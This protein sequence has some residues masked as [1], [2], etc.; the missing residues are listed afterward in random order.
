MYWS[1]VDTDI[2]DGALLDHMIMCM[3]LS[4]YLTLHTRKQAQCDGRII[5]FFLHIA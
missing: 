2:W 4:Q 5:H 1:L 3:L